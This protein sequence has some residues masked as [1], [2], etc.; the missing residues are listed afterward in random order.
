M[1]RG[2]CA[3]NAVG[4]EVADAGEHLRCRRGEVVDAGAP[5]LDSV[6]QGSPHDLQEDA[7]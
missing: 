5:S 6:D 1:L 4:Y 7:E 3:C 2:R